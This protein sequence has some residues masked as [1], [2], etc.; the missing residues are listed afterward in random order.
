MF[1]AFHPI[2]DSF[3]FINFDLIL[4][5]DFDLKSR[6]IKRFLFTSDNI[7]CDDFKTVT[8]LA[9]EEYVE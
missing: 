4:S 7:I 2:L 5:G 1:Y 9:L 8:C 6:V 3:D